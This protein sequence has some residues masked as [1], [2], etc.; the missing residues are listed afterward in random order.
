MAKYLNGSFWG[1]YFGTA[2][3][4]GQVPVGEAEGRRLENATRKVAAARGV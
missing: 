4:R 2:A 1:G 3:V